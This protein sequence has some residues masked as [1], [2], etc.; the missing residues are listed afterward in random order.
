VRALILN[1]PDPFQAA[2]RYVPYY[3]FLVGFIIALVTMLKGLKHVGI[4]LT[5]GQSILFAVLFG[6][7]SM[8]VGG[9]FVR[10]IPYQ[11]E[12]NQA[13]HFAGVERIFGVLMVFTACAMAFAH[14][15]NDV[16]NAIGPVAAIVGILETGDISNESPVP[17]W[18]LV[19]G[20]AG[21]VGG[22]ITYGHRV[23]ATV[24]ERITEL[25]PS[26][27]FAATLA[28]ATTVVVASGTG[29]PISTTHTLVGAVLGVGLARGIAAIELSVVRS[30]FASWIVTLPVGAA[31]SVMFYYML[32]FTFG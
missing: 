11:F 24:G 14:G 29:L 18:I 12:E 22:L 15:S 9:F 8:L 25:T 4:D 19:V 7:A 32:K 3:I 17:I 26:R 28:A 21:I 5:F 6:L 13:F 16:A 1:A 2:R 10:R 31:L 23:M 27:G 30:V 20:G